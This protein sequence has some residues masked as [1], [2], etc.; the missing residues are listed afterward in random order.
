MRYHASMNEPAVSMSGRR[1]KAR[2]A[3][4][5][6]TPRAS[7]ALRGTFDR[8]S[9]RPSQTGS[10]L[11][12]AIGRTT[13]DALRRSPRTSANAA[14]IAA[15]STR[16]RPHPPIAR[17]ATASSGVSLLPDL[18]RAQDTEGHRTDA[19]VGDRGDGDAADDRDRD[20]ASRLLHLAGHD[21][22]AHEAVPRPEEDRRP[23]EQAK[24]LVTEDRSEAAGV[25]G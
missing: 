24:A 23:G 14:R 20:G 18:I 5:P 9:I 7:T 1:S 19:D 2:S 4:A 25:E 12:R 16:P 21:R 13:R 10:S 8:A 11:A 15:A 3:A 17:W 22:H 6:S